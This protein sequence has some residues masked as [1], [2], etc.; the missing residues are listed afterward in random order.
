MDNLVPTAF[1][2]RIYRSDALEGAGMNWWLQNDECCIQRT[3]AKPHEEL[4]QAV[5]ESQPDAK[6]EALHRRLYPGGASQ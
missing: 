4:G 3:L 1:V 5:V 6:Q 2:V